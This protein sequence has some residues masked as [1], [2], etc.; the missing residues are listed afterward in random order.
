[1][2]NK[3]INFNQKIIQNNDVLLK[4]LDKSAVILNLNNETY[5]GI[6]ETSYSMY[7]RLIQS[8]SIEEAYQFFCREFNEDPE[9]I[10][11]DLISFIQELLDNKVIKIT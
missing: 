10:K 7:K 1:M 9:I 11:K 8:S 4:E 5:Y 2:T 6:D 3:T